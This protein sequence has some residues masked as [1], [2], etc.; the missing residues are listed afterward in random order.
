MI[1][2]ESKN[3]HSK[4]HGKF[5][6]I[7]VFDS[8]LGGLTV[9]RAIQKKLPLETIV[10][11]GDTARIPY[12][13][14][15][16]E[17]IIKYSQQIIRFLETKNVKYIVVA[18]NTS[19][20]WALKH[21]MRTSNVPV[22]GVINPGACKAVK[23]TKNGR[24]GVTGTLGTVN[25]HA[26]QKSIQQISSKIVLKEIPCPLFVPLVE[27]G[28]Y[29]GNIVC[30]IAKNYLRQLIQF[31]IDTLV[32][33]CTH[34]PL[35]KSVLQKVVGKGVTIIDS[36]DETAAVLKI[37]LEEFGLLSHQ[38]RAD[39]YFVSDFLTQQFQRLAQQF[40]RQKIQH[41]QKIDID[42]Y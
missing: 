39:N 36:A 23:T 24:I 3:L 9:V 31:R 32:L 40:L 8:G 26:Y 15:S 12:G 19:T 25:S 42:K 11:F 10:Y 7:G 28:M 27:E 18:C 17:V 2:Q 35:L 29:S 20:A 34:Y 14:K 5:Q 1:K 33:G 21:L 6:P 37:K 13:N 41:I 22:L 16:P 38:K 30:H 4:F